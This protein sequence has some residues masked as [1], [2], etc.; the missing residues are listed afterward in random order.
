MI[1]RLRGAAGR[2]APFVL[3]APLLLVGCLGS[4]V[5]VERISPREADRRL[6]AN[7][8]ATG[9]PSLWSAQTLHRQKLSQVHARSPEAA[10]KRGPQTS[11]VTPG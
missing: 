9:Q 11:S 3:L 8:L 7:V 10:S 1:D 4:P 2:L 5:G 6:A